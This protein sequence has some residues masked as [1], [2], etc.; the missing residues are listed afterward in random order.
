M[1]FP[2]YNFRGYTSVSVSKWPFVLWRVM[3]ELLEFE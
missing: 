3:N 2:G 1:V